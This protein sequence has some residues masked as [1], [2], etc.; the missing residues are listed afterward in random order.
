MKTVFL[1]LGLH[2]TGTT[3]IQVAMS[4]ES[5]AISNLGVLYPSACRPASAE[6]GHHEIAW[7]VMQRNDYIPE[8]WA[9][10][11]EGRDAVRDTCFEK[12]LKEIEESPCKN[13]LVS[14]EELDCLSRSEIEDIAQRFS[15][16]RVCPI[17][18]L[19]NLCDFMESA[20]KTYVMYSSTVDSI[21]QFIENQRTRIDFYDLI[22]DW[23]SVIESGEMFVVD[24]DDL[25]VRSNSL[26]VLC[27]CIG[28]DY[29]SLPTAIRRDNE[30]A[31]AALVE[32]V[33]FLRMIEMPKT[34]IDN[35]IFTHGQ[36]ISFDAQ[37]TLLSE[38]ASADLLSRYS[39]EIESILKIDDTRLKILGNFEKQAIPRRKW[40]S[41]V[42][43]AILDLRK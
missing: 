1:H 41:P 24:Y 29:N 32:I 20:Y 39:R 6:F 19:R 15:G 2:K 34:V 31:S 7:A 42:G 17:L 30:S 14:S 35:W 3:S 21:S 37:T 12:L 33:R 36:H 25:A 22:V 13:V 5:E 18:Y 27:K 40:I 38:D 4:T 43:H 23:L 26:A 16:Y 8:D 9:G 11:G 28:L 10:S